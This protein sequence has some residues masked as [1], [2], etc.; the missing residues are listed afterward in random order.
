MSF[1]TFKII[2]LSV[3]VNQYSMFKNIRHSLIGV[4]CSV[5]NSKGF[6]VP[7]LCSLW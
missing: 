1:S 6:S 7:T 4:P 5:F 3:I 2:Q